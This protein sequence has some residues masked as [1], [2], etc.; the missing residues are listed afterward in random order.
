MGE[1]ADIRL[2][3]PHECLHSFLVQFVH[4][5]HELAVLDYVGVAHVV[6]Q[7]LPITLH[8]TILLALFATKAHLVRVLRRWLKIGDWLLQLG[9]LEL[10]DGGLWRVGLVLERHHLLLHPPSILH[11]DLPLAHDLLSHALPHL[12]PS[13]SLPKLIHFD[14]ALLHQFIYGGL[15]VR[16]VLLPVEF[17][18]VEFRPLLGER[19]LELV[20][21][22]VKLNNLTG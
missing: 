17:F 15:V 5:I 14:F 8:S 10:G 12:R 11:H 19:G 21:F 7:G 6:F 4:R 18:L 3:L 2:T 9:V 16:L 1:I 22:L 13:H 20:A